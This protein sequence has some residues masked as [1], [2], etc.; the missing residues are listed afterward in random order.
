MS[1][2]VQRYQKL[3]KRD[4]NDCPVLE[5][6]TNVLCWKPDL[7]AG[8]LGINWSGPYKIHRRLS[9]D[10]YIVKCPFT[11]KEYR[12]H[13]SLIRPLRRKLQEDTTEFINDEI[14]KDAKD[15]IP[16]HKIE[17]NS[18]TKL[19]SSPQNQKDRHE[20]ADK[21]DNEDKSWIPRLRPRR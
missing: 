9:K 1:L 19:T 14:K 5:I 6:G 17:K 7:L 21:V 3:L 12:R 18:N 16:L 20:P 10:S 2:A 15:Q 13:I 8:K 11:K 4:K